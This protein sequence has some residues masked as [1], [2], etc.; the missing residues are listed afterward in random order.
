MYKLKTMRTRK[1]CTSLKFELLKFVYHSIF[2]ISSWG[3][4]KASSKTW[5]PRTSGRR[6]M[7]FLSCEVNAIVICTVLVRACLE[8]ALERLKALSDNQK[9]DRWM[10]AS[11][12]ISPKHALCFLLFHLH[13][14]YTIGAFK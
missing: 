11:Y 14:H 6:G 4:L 2:F 1:F 9:H 8:L 5:R 10:S 3:L 13:H 7:N 12:R